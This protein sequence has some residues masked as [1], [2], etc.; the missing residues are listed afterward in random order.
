MLSQ[1][2]D[3]RIRNK[4]MDKLIKILR[5][6]GFEAYPSKCKPKTNW[7]TGC[8]DPECCSQHPEAIIYEINGRKFAK[9]PKSWAAITTNA[10]S[11][12][13]HSALQK[14]YPNIK[15]TN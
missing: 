6:Q 12:I 15:N 8:C 9:M 11:N 14:L 2:R 3:Y 5:E 10:S 1:H 4:N 7:G 13:V